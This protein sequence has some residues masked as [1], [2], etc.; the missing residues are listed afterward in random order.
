MT[1]EERQ[2]VTGLF[3]RMR[4]YSLTETDAE[5]EALIHERVRAV[6]DAPYMLVQ[7]VLV[8]EQA[9]EQAESRIKALEEQV[10]ALESQQRPAGTGSFLGGLFGSR[11]AAESS[12]GPSVPLVGSRATPPVYA[13]GQPAQPGP[14][15]AQPPPPAQPG[16]FPGQAA[17]SGGGGFLRTAMATATGVAGGMLVAGAIRNLMTPAH[18]ADATP[19]AAG[20]TPN[21]TGSG[22]A[23]PAAASASAG[24]TATPEPAHEE[25]AH[26]EPA[27]AAEEDSGWFGDG[28]DDFD[29]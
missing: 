11:P 10:R 27:H 26:V 1:P 21:V 19:S 7:S 3:D 24:E 13:G 29:L 22:E 16:V 4:N 25:P 28:G 15:G 20:A 5:A 9:L 14:F 23:H 17:A 2:L 12:R 6:P 8:Q 18:A